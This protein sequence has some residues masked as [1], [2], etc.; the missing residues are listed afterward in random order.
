MEGKRR[1]WDDMEAVLRKRK[2]NLLDGEREMDLMAKEKG[3]KEQGW[4]EMNLKGKKKGGEMAE[5]H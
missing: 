2:E 3:W 5:E 1:E 4:E